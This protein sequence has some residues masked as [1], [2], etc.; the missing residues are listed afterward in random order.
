M[1]CIVL[2]GAEGATEAIGF[3]ETDSMYLVVD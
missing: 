2:A 1:E 3:F